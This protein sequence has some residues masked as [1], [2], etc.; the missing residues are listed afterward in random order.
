MNYDELNAE[1]GRKKIS[2][3]KLATAIGIGKKAMYER[4]SGK[5]QFRQR[6]IVAIRDT[7]EL[8]DDKLMEIFFA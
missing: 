6:E 8:S 7:L 5:Q 4:F 1:M 2:I 3:P